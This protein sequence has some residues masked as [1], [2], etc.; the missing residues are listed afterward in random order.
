MLFVFHF[1]K[2]I[3]QIGFDVIES[4]TC[5]NEKITFDLESFHRSNLELKMKRMFIDHRS[6]DHREVDFIAMNGIST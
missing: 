4:V 1:E 3:D 5:L 6:T 2:T